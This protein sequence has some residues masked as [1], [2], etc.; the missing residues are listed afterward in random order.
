MARIKEKFDGLRERFTSD[1]REYDCTY[2]IHGVIS[3]SDFPPSFQ[4]KCKGMSDTFAR[5]L[6][7]GEL[8]QLG[9][10]LSEVTINYS[11]NPNKQSKRKADQDQPANPLARTIRRSWSIGCMDLRKTADWDGKVFKNAAG[12]WLRDPPACKQRYMIRRY[13]RNE[14]Y[15]PEAAALECGYAINSSPVFGRGQWQVLC[16][17]FS[18]SD[19]MQANGT[20]YVEVDYEFWLLNGQKTWKEVRID[21]GSY[22][23]ASSSGGPGGGIITYPSTANGA[24][25]YGDEEVFLDATGYK[26]SLAAVA[27]GNVHT[28]EF[29]C[30]ESSDFNMLGLP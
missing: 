5:I 29:R 26:L 24:T 30:H 19:V 4:W 10:D 17:N 20:D 22:W 13:T 14:A 3:A 23:L 27:A 25:I 9:P 21:A 8:R 2:L 11:T 16:A 28:L 7:I 1:R 15:F 18:G 12:Q 6:S